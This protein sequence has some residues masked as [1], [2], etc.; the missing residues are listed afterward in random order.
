MVIIP[1]PLSLS[2]YH[3]KFQAYTLLILDLNCLFY[4][5]SIPLADIIKQTKPTI[6]D[7]T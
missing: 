4:S 3:V 6:E 7:T 2:Y 1:D 5:Y